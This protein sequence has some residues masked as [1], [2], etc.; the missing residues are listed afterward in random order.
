MV[1]TNP[2]HTLAPTVSQLRTRQLTHAAPGCWLQSDPVRAHDDV[3]VVGAVGPVAYH[4]A[5]SRSEG[6]DEVLP[7]LGHLAPLVPVQC[8]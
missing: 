5:H 3:V 6:R 7:D 4:H 8:S 1:L 2:T